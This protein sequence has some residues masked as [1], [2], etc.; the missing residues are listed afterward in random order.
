VSP[1]S[2]VSNITQLL[3][4][5]H[6]PATLND[7][8]SVIIAGFSITSGLNGTARVSHATPEPDLLDPERP[9]DDEVTAARHRMVNAYAETL[10]A[11]GYTVERRGP[12]SRRPYLLA[13]R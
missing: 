12:H 5:S 2:L 9:S 11:A 13:S 3:S 6:R 1:S 4:A 10:E 8:G 7:Y